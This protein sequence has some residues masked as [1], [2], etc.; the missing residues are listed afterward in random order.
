MY[1]QYDYS[2]SGAYGIV[3]QRER[4]WAT[5]SV[6]SAA[7]R[8]VDEVVTAAEANEHVYLL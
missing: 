5:Q 2:L 8:Q 7:Q 4:E 1:V 6:H 3:R